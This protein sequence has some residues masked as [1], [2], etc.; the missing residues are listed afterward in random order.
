MVILCLFNYPKLFAQSIINPTGPDLVEVGVDEFCDIDVSLSNGWSFESVEW[1]TP[2]LFGSTTIEGLP[3]NSTSGVGVI[4]TD[5]DPVLI[6]F[7]SNAAGLIV[8][9]RARVTFKKGSEKTTTQS[10]IFVKVRGI[11]KNF[12]V[13]G[14]KTITKC[15]DVGQTFCAASFCDFSPCN[16]FTFEWSVSPSTWKISGSNTTECITVIPDKTNAGT[17]TC[18]IRR[19]LSNPVQTAT[20][21]I[22]ITRPNP[23]V[24]VTGPTENICPGEIHTYTMK[25][26]SECNLSSRT[27]VLPKGWK[28]ISGQNT[29]T[30]KAVV[31]NDGNVSVNLSYIGGCQATG[32]LN[33]PVLTSGPLQPSIEPWSGDCYV[34]YHCDR[35]SFCPNSCGF[36]YAKVYA[37]TQKLRWEIKGPWSFNLGGGKLVQSYEQNFVVTNSS[38]NFLGHDV[39]SS[40]CITG[41]DTGWGQYAGSVSV[42]AINCTGESPSEPADFYQEQYG[43]CK[44]D[45]IGY[46]SCYPECFSCADPDKY[47]CGGDKQ[48][49]V[50]ASIS[51]NPNQGTFNVDANSVIENVIIYNTTGSVISTVKNQSTTKNVNIDLQNSPNGLYLLD[52]Q[53]KDSS[54]PIRK[55]IV[56]Q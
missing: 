13:S 20:K 49:E 18:T 38:V 45:E 16:G 33:V 10:D 3:S 6:N 52:I 26:S 40:S 42:T 36:M 32:I 28:I 50:K 24:N 31:G 4:L 22:A 17:V 7:A 35:W 15:C 21:A 30:I 8:I 53:T 54:T 27:W 5:T 2:F 9:V 12:F 37:G 39:V 44:E 34:N 56:K 47:G 41:P 11:S 55:T 43:F 1:S 46:Y 19:L 51:P 29:N 23:T 14:P 25:T 48:F